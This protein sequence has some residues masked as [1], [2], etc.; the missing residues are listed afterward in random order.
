M[1]YFSN[2]N[3]R[4]IDSK[5]WGHFIPFNQLILDLKHNYMAIVII[6]PKFKLTIKITFT[7]L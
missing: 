3:M 6:H 4:G 5:V 2:E 1:S 7:K